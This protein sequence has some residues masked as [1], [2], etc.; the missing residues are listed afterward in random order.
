MYNRLTT[1]LNKYYILS[2][3]Q[4]VFKEKKSTNTAIQ[5]FIE[6]IQGGLDSE[7]QAIGIFYDL[8]KAYNVSNHDVP[9]DKLNSYGVRGN[10]NSWFKS[11][12]TDR[13]QIVEIKQSDHINSRQ[14][15]LFFL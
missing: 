14:Y 4:N 1:Y 12:L 11:H 8:T 10:I 9:L 5:S 15:K 3:S 2:E 6:R 13:K 7:L